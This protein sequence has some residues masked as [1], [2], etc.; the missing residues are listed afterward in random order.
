MQRSTQRTHRICSW[1]QAR[2]NVGVGE[3]GKSMAQSQKYSTVSCYKQ[4][5][6]C[7]Q[8]RQWKSRYTSA[9][10][11]KG[12]N[13]DPLLASNDPCETMGATIH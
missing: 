6:E 11:K 5:H 2:I 7:T 4:M 9:H 1:H 13:S 8:A 10:S 12:S 3:V